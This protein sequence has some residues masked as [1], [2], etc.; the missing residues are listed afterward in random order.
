MQFF[1]EH[2]WKYGGAVLQAEDEIAG[3]GAAIGA[4]S[5]EESHDRHVRP[6]SLKTEMMGLASIAK[7]P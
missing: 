5:R 2:V 1:T 6:L 4:S 7:P 3:I